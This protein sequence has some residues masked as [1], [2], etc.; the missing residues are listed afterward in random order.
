M[1]VGN[2]RILVRAPIPLSEHALTGWL[3]SWLDGS[4][5]HLQSILVNMAFNQPVRWEFFSVADNIDMI[6]PLKALISFVQWLYEPQTHQLA[7]QQA[8]PIVQWPLPWTAS[9]ARATQVK[10]VRSKMSFGC[11]VWTTFDHLRCCW[12]QVSNEKNWSCLECIHIVLQSIGG[13]LITK[14]LWNPKWPTSSVERFFVA[15]AMFFLLQLDVGCLMLPFLS[16][17]CRISEIL[18]WVWQS[19]K[20]PVLSEKSCCCFCHLYY[21][22]HQK[23]SL[24]Y[25][26]IRT[27]Q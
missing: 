15:Q 26:W 19:V 14:P 21:P 20:S 3:L 2:H 6:L 16:Q 27:W 5:H 25:P 13:I 11:F 22:L 17:S 10:V 12:C 8:R 24:Y 23:G 18:G 4:L 7:Q 9:V 1:F